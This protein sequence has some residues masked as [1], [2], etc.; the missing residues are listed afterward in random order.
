[1]EHDFPTKPLGEVCKII[2][3]QSPPGSTYNE[4]G[5]G[6]PFF[7]GVADFGSRYPTR[8][9]W[10]SAPSRI[11][12]PGDVLLSIRAP[13][14]D[15]N[16]ASE[17]CAVGRGIA[18]V[19][20][21]SHEDQTFVEFVLRSARSTWDAMEGSGTVFANAT[22]SQLET[23]E[24]PWPD[25]GSRTAIAHL[26]GSLD[27]KIDLNRRMNQTLEEI[28]RALFKFWFVDFGPVR[29]KAEGRWRK[30]ESLPGLPA[31]TWDLWP[32]EFEES[33]IGEIPKG[34]AVRPL[35]EL[36][37]VIFSGGTPDTRKPEYWEGD[38]PWLSSGETRSHFVIDSERTITEEAVANS[39][40]RLA[41]QGDI[42][43]A[44]AGQGNTRGQVSRCLL[45]A[46][47]NQSMVAVRP[48]SIEGLGGFLYSSLS[49][50]YLE[51]RGIS[52]SH[53]IRGSLTTRMLGDLR[54]I[55]PPQ[56]L[57]REFGLQFGP[58][59]GQIKSNLFE[60]RTLSSLRDAL[61]PKLL[62]GEIRVKVDS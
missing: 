25:D 44:A 58:A 15:V 2:M 53:A 23:L 49:T 42:L 50:R 4:S 11:A 8:R 57:L 21:R 13:I 17:R 38:L 34:W 7:Q 18:I 1:M 12:E 3:G 26:L 27:D 32:S 5:E 31:D 37:E 28:C 14:G 52:D 9:V 43:I 20:A 41:R 33:E 61:L 62:S 48:K 30:G 40:T 16:L 29:A 6:L 59:E 24:V 22:R 54:V 56:T 36:A 51:L 60:T 35:G 10:C 55:V 19:R 47:I 45:D 39:S 46:Y